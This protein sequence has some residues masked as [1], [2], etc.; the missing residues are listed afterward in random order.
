MKGKKKL[1][2]IQVH[3]CEQSICLELAYL[4]LHL[5]AFFFCMSNKQHAIIIIPINF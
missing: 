1:T 3:L 4:A 2:L 5:K